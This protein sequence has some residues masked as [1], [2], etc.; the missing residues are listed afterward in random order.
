M[1]H[2]QLI[3]R[4][5]FHT[6]F[7]GDVLAQQPVEVLVAASLPTAIRV[8]KVGLDA[9]GLNGGQVVCKLFAIVHRQGLDPRAQGLELG[10]NGLAY[11]VR[12]L[13]AHLGQHGKA[14]LAFD[15]RH[16]CLFVYGANNSIDLPVAH[17]ALQRGLAAR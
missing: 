11:Q 9:Q 16:D 17:L 15:Q 8:S 6:P 3:F 10:L 13:V 14:A 4:H 12:R 7:L 1:D 2:S 5:G